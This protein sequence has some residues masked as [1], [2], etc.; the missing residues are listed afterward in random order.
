MQRT[1][2]LSFAVLFSVVSGQSQAPNTARRALAGDPPPSGYTR[3]INLWPGEAP[4]ARGNAP[5]DVP[6]LYYYPPTAMG[7]H[8]AVIVMPG[9]GYVHEVMEKEGAAEARWLAARGVAAFV[10]QYRVAPEYRYPVPMLDGARAVRYLRSH[11][12]EYGLDPDRIGVWGF[13]AGGH[14]AG[15]LATAPIASDKKS[16]DPVE[17]VNEHPDFA[18]FSYA[19]LSMDPAIPRAT[20]MEPLIGLNPRPE[21]IDTVWIARHV[22][23]ETSPSFIYSTTA[24][25]TVNS[26]NATAY[27]DACK[28]EGVPVE[29]HIFEL[30]AHGTGMGQNLRGEAEL[31]IWP[32]LLQHWMQLHG[33]MS[34][35]LAER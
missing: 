23:K 6:K 32:L 9:G 30:G 35:T 2:L 15:Y 25:Q 22:T 26:M 17:R 8:S 28:R 14:L 20:N 18:I 29:L 21:M 7:V 27:Y 34:P 24:D 13:S 4:M 12:T 19:R 16:S 10:L 31:E 3:V 1:F 33:W 5:A 11:A